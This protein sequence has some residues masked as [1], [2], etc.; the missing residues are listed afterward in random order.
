M[1]ATIDITLF[2]EYFTNPVVI[3]I[4][5]RSFPIQEYFLEDCIELTNFVPI[6]DSKKKNKKVSYCVSCKIMIYC[7]VAI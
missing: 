5:G 7:S 1:S 3:E 4:E 2:S 6:P